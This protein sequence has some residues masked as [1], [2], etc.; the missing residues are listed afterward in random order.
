MYHGIKCN[1]VVHPYRYSHL[2]KYIFLPNNERMEDFTGFQSSNS[3]ISLASF[4]GVEALHPYAAL[5]V[6]TG[7]FPPDLALDASDCWDLFSIMD[8]VARASKH[9]DIIGEVEKLRPKVFFGK[10]ECI[11]SADIIKYEAALRK[12]IERWIESPS[13]KGIMASV[14]L[15]LGGTI[16]KQVGIM[17]K[18]FGDKSPYDRNEYQKSLLPLLDRLNSADALPALVFHYDRHGI[19]CLAQELVS[20][21]EAAEKVWK[22]GS[23][24]WQ[25]RMETWQEWQAQAKTRQ[26]QEDKIMKSIKGRIKEEMIRDNEPSWLESFDPE[27]PLPQFSFQ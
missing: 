15:A 20:A 22:E 24:A 26:K 8:S 4:S 21:L 14:T 16:D 9:D 2:R 10:T 23:S 1:L 27:T 11:K 13:C 5:A 19:E 3:R 18:S 12:V 7:T 17:E 25:S 6:A